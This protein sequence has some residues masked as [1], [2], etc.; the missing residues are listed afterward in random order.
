MFGDA[1][2][3]H[4]FKPHAQPSTR[5]SEPSLFFFFIDK[6]YMYKVIRQCASLEYSTYTSSSHTRTK[7]NTTNDNY[8]TNNNI[9]KERHYIHNK[10]LKLLETL[11]GFG[12]EGIVIVKKYVIFYFSPSLKTF[13]AN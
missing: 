2:R 6:I 8:H 12:I 5:K 9:G 1:A 11:I 13:K 4:L 10:R 7:W 3:H